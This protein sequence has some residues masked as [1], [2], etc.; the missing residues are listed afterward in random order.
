[1]FFNN[2]IANTEND[3]KI[4]NWNNEF[5]IS[6]WT[7]KLRF[8]NS[9][10]EEREQEEGHYNEWSEMKLHESWKMGE[11]WRRFCDELTFIVPHVLIVWL[12]DRENAIKMKVIIIVSTNLLENC[13]IIPIYTTTV[14]LFNENLNS[15]QFITY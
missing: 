13:W 2:E 7:R 8:V 11:R 4:E 3:I 10:E 6:L 14:A 15:K 12:I 5:C 1:M 9:L